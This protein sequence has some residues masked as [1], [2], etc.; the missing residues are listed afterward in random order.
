MKI[1]IAVFIVLIGLF[2]WG[3]VAGADNDIDDDDEKDLSGLL[4]DE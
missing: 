4:E 3:L 2:C 1:A